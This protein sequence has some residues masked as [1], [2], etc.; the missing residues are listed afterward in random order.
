MNKDQK[1]KQNQRLRR[2]KKKVYKLNYLNEELD[3]VIQTIDEYTPEFNE[4]LM[5]W[6]TQH[7]ATDAIDDMFPKKTEEEILA[8]IS[9]EKEIEINQ[10]NAN[11]DPWAKEI[12]RQIANETHPDKIDQMSELSDNE[13]AVRGEI[14]VNA[15]K[16][17]Q[18]N[19]GPAL[20]VLAIELKLKMINVPD[21]I[22]EYFDKSVDDLQEKI[23]SAQNSNVWYW[24]ESP[25][26]V[27]A[28]FLAKISEKYKIESN[29][30]EIAQ[31]LSDYIRKE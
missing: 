20:Y 17:L 5:K 26:H 8:E 13:K 31:F 23:N 16:L 27:R 29:E 19:D 24:A 28:H 1:R 9:E 4:A 22:L 3:D 21:N 14:F 18:E 7:N 15:N 2:L 11:I 25:C 12:Y 10:K 30:S 6:F